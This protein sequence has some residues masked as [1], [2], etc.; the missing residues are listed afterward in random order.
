MA[1]IDADEVLPNEHV[2]QMAAKG[3]ITQMHRGHQY[4]EEGD[5]FEIDG[6]RFAVTDVTH[7]KLG[8]LTDEDAQR[9]GSDDLEAYKRRLERVHDGFEWDPESDVVRHRFEPVEE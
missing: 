3:S 4:A 5:S 7:R 1:K 8:D 6:Q 2:Q 9:E